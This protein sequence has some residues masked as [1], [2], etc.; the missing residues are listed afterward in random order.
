[1]HNIMSTEVAKFEGRFRADMSID[2]DGP[3]E[4]AI[5]EMDTTIKCGV[6]G[7]SNVHWFNIETT[8]YQYSDHFVAQTRRRPNIVTRGK[9]NAGHS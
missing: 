3:T 1:M 9:P 7:P 8:L 6:K 2:N 5:T 4:V